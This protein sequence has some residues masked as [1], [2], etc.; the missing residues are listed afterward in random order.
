MTDHTSQF[1]VQL[2]DAFRYSSMYKSPPKKNAFEKAIDVF[3]IVFILAAHITLGY[4]L[5]QMVQL[6]KVTARCTETGMF[7]TEGYAVTCK[8][9]NN[10]A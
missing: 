10:K 2:A 7:L 3:M 8:V 9:L 1:N 5:G 6:N 4:S